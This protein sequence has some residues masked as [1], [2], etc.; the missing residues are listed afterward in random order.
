MARSAF[1]QCPEGIY[2]TKLRMAYATLRYQYDISP[3]LTRLQYTYH[4][5]KLFSFQSQIMLVS[6]TR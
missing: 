2:C 5:L 3:S 6:K 1:M 4:L